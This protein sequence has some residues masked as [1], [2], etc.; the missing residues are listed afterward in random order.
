MNM[1]NNNSKKLKV[2]MIAP[3]PFFAD[4]GCHMQILEEIKALKKLGVDCAVTTYHIGRD[5][6]GV[7]IN[8]IINI[9]WYK[10]L[11]AG[12]SL[13]KIYLDALLFFKTLGV[14][15]KEKPDIIHGHLHEG[16]LIGWPLAKLSG[17][18]LLFDLQDSLSHEVKEHGYKGLKYKIFSWL[19]KQINKMPNLIVT[20]STTMIDDLKDRF[21]V[22]EDKIHLTM[23]GADVES[24]K[25]NLDTTELRE[26]HKIPSDKK[27]VLY[28]G[29]LTETKGVD[30]LIKAIPEVIKKKKDAFFLIMGYPNVEHYQQMAKD[31][32]VPDENILF[33]GGIDYSKA[34]HY[35]N[36]GHLAVSPKCSDTEAN[37]KLYNYMACGLPVVSFDTGVDREILGDYGVYA[38]K[39]NH[40]DMADKIIELL[41]DPEKMNSN[42][43]KL[44]DRVVEK[45]S[46]DAVGQRIY[47]CYNKM[48][49]RPPLLN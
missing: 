24:F 10:K 8:R 40:I 44:R 18:P 28:L 9:P 2:L 21:A 43:I 38:E 45:Y 3:T 34:P 25:P 32:G 33:T 26:K 14:Y 5:V 37:G 35:L 13:H 17:K 19:E 15:F 31:L 48:L 41:N 29:G 42:S 22:S 6:E 11:S 39:A 12:P 7:N 47:A 20:Q 23:D 49:N 16:C 36:L 4:R 46:W 27:I 30:H 1:Q